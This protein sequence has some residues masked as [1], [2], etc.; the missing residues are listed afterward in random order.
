MEIRNLE[1]ESVGELWL[2]SSLYIK[3]KD[4]CIFKKGLFFFKAPMWI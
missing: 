4:H 2:L 3:K 1:G